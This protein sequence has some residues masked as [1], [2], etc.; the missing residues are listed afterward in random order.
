MLP[1]LLHGE[2]RGANGAYQGQGEAIWQ[3]A[4]LAQDKTSRRVRYKDFVDEL[5]RARTGENASRSE[6]EHT[7]RILKRILGFEK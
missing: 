6:V 2:E 7:F 5:Q 3:A 4:P 1:D